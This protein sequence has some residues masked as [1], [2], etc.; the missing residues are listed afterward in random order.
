MIIKTLS[1]N[2]SVSNQFCFEHGLSLYIETSDKKLLFDVGASG[3][4]YENAKKLAVEISDIDFLVISHGHYD[5]G[6]GLE[7][8]LAEN[9]KALVYIHN[10]A[11]EGYFAARDNSEIDYIGL[12]QKLKQNERIILTSD[13]FFI[14]KG[15]EVFSN[16]NCKQPIGKTNKGLM[17][18]QQ[19]QIISDSFAH[20]QILIIEENGKRALVTGCA[21]NGLIN[22]LE[23]FYMLK[24][25][26][27]DYVI[28]GFHLSSRQG[29]AAADDEL[30]KIAAYLQGTKAKYYTCHCT[31]EDAYNYL[32]NILGDDIEY[33]KAGSEIEI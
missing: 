3:I 4:F 23:H 11:F 7:T 25:C 30:D 10:L 18:K 5:H 12:E 20:E 28:G 8:F 1:E 24:G 27:P 31:G 13:R 26:M 32:K 15:I 6:G 2:T 22:I 29:A 19:G 33:I 14:T 9:D 16:I 21:H 17:T